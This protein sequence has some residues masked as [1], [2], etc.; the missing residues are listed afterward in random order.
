MVNLSLL[1]VVDVSRKKFA[2]KR[3]K[4]WLPRANV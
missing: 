1:V 3:E 2:R 4:R